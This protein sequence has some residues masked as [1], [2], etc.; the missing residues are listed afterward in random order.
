MNRRFEATSGLFEG[1]AVLERQI[2][3]GHLGSPASPA[4]L[5]NTHD[6]TEDWG[7]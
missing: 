4:A 1:L 5:Y 6:P 3:Q 2:D 7:A